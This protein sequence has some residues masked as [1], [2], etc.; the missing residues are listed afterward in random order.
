[1][2]N[3]KEKKIVEASPENPQPNQSNRIARRP[4]THPTVEKSNDMKGAP[5]KLPHLLLILSL[6][7]LPAAAAT[8]RVIVGDTIVL[9]GETV[10]ILNIDAPELHRSGCDPEKRLAVLARKRIAPHWRGTR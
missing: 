6:F 1:M 2:M 9:A 10:R 8:P 3:F 4:A 5:M 7:A